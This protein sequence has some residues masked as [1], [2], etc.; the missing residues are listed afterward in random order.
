MGVLDD[1]ELEKTLIGS[2]E[3]VV[4]QLELGAGENGLVARFVS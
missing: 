4:T 2:L 1:I 3:N